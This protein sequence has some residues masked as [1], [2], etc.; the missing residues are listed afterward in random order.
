[1][2]SLADA[3]VATLDEVVGEDLATLDVT[4]PEA[5]RPFLITGLARRGTPVLAVT[6]TSR[7]AEDLVEVLGGLLGK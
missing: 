6:A 7:E 2:K 3:A 5:L 4:G 1:M